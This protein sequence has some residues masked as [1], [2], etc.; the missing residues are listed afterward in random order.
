MTLKVNATISA[1]TGN[2]QHDANVGVQSLTQATG[3]GGTPGV[4][5]ATTTAANIDFGDVTA[6]YV[7]CRNL[8]TGNTAE[9]LV[10]GTSF[11]KLPPAQV[12]LLHKSTTTWQIRAT[13]GTALVDVRGFST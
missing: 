4:V 9:L 8:S 6:G 13:S 11:G 1:A 12:Q 2:F 7:W 10:G 5:S 3:S